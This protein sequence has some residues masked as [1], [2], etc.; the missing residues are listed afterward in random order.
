[1]KKILTLSLLMIAGIVLLASC[2][3]RD[4][5]DDRNDVEIS[6]IFEVSD[7]PYS[8]I[9]FNN[10]GTYAIIEHLENNSN[11]W[12][13]KGDR[14]QGRFYEGKE[15]TVYNLTAGYNNRVYVVEVG[16]LTIDDAWDALDYYVDDFYAVKGMNKSMKMSF[17][18]RIK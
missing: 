3:K 13:I 2:T 9:Q 15:S 17:E 4:Y 10:D 14:L 5:Y 18:R 7:S 8:I 16:I 12:P 6:V 11:R 1:M